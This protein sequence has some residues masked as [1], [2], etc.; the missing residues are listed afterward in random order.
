MQL[1]KMCAKNLLLLLYGMLWKRAWC[2]DTLTKAKKKAL[3]G[4]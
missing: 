2:L 1:P 4:F 3:A